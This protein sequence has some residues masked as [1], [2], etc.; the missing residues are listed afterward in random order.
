MASSKTRVLS[1]WH[2]LIFDSHSV[3]L[4]PIAK[5]GVRTNRPCDS[6][7]EGVDTTYPTG[8]RSPVSLLQP[9]VN[10]EGVV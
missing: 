2:K 3:V 1:A 8:H 9:A 10:H 6:S 7:E 5:T 4:P